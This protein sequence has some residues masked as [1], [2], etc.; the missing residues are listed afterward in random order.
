MAE[1]VPVP[2]YDH[3]VAVGV[4]SLQ[5]NL[6]GGVHSHE[7]QAVGQGPLV[8]EAVS[9]LAVGKPLV[10]GVVSLE[11]LLASEDASTGKSEVNLPASCEVG[12]LDGGWQFGYLGFSHGTGN[13]GLRAE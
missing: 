1:R 4:S 10:G 7:Q 12:R 8:K 13:V 3:G 2:A 5:A 9:T 11:Q 6:E